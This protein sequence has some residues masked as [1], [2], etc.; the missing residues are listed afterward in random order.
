[1]SVLRLIFLVLIVS[2]NRDGH[3]KKEMDY[4][5]FAA[6]GS[7]VFD[8]YPATTI[9]E[10]HLDEGKRLGKEVVVK[11]EIIKIGKFNTHLVIKDQVGKILVILT[12]MDNIDDFL[13]Q[14]SIRNIEVLG[15][16]ERGKK[17]LPYVLARSIHIMEDKK[18]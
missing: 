10:I 17:G 16:I 15:S 11:G 1:M 4:T 8:N 6:F 7:S 18:R 14:K 2:C 12:Q 5:I 3:F 13:K 9:K